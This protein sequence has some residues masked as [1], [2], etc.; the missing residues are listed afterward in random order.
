MERITDSTSSI[1]RAHPA[2]WTRGHL[3]RVAAR[4]A[5]LRRPRHPRGRGAAACRPAAG[6]LRQP[7]RRRRPGGERLGSRGKRFPA[8]HRPRAADRGPAGA[9][10]ARAAGAVGV[11]VLAGLCLLVALRYGGGAVVA[12]L[13]WGYLLSV[14]LTVLAVRRAGQPASPALDL[15]G[16]GTVMALVPV[17]AAIVAALIRMAIYGGTR[18]VRIPF[19][20][21]V[22]R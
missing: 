20:P 3:R 14:V 2:Q 22:G 15:P 9:V 13:C 6:P 5:D 17:A 4:R 8:D 10:R 12:G 19:T 18:N 16:S 21:T 7:T 1:D 11:T